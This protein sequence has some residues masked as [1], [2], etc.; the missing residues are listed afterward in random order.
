M[1]LA[2]YRIRANLIHPGWTDTPGERKF[3]SEETLR[4]RARQLPLG[5]LARPDDIARGVSFLADP[6][7]DYITGTTLLIDGGINLPFDQLHRL[8][9]KP[10]SPS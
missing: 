10:A 2:E 5:R 4:E 1:E 9:E 6:A 7:N 8:K 3:F